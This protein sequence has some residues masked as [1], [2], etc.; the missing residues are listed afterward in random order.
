MFDR[1]KEHRD[2]TATKAV[3]VTLECPLDGSSVF[4][5]IILLMT[6]ELCY[7]LSLTRNGVRTV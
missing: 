5:M 3:S 4:A 1:Q 6:A 7:A 2:H